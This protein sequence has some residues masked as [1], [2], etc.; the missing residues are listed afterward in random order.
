[1]W[2]AGASGHARLGGPDRGAPDQQ[3]EEAMPGSLKLDVFNAGYRPIPSAIPVWPKGWQATWPATTV[4]LLSGDR[5]AILVDSLFTKAESQELA[6][7][8]AAAGK[9]LTEVYI[10]HG[11]ADHF[12]GLNTVLE[13]NPDAKAVALAEIVPFLQE[14]V[15]PGWMQIWA[16]ILPDPLFDQPAVPVALE[17]P[18]LTVEGYAFIPIKFGQSDV[19]DSSVVHAPDLDTLIAGDVIYNDIH[20]WMSQSDHRTRTA[21]IQTLNDVEKLH[22]ATVIAGH[23]DPE[24]PDNDGSRLIDQ[25]RHYIHDFDQAVAASS[26]GQEVVSRMTNKYPDLGNPYTLWLAAYTQPYGQ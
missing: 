12:F 11:H 25:T 4:S 26:S 6:D 8:L 1:V 5:D 15:T 21:W 9:H 19:S 18:E 20:P 7:W 16:S 24:A 22:P 13:T 10:T 2:Q 3:E 23:A 17:K 14:Q